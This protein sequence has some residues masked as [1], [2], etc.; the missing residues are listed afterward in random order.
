M[1]P[2]ES[3]DKDARVG[4]HD[5]AEVRL[6]LEGG[7]E[8]IASQRH[9]ARADPGD[10]AVGSDPLPHEPRPPDLGHGGHDEQ[11]DGPDHAHVPGDPL[12]LGNGGGTG[13]ES[14]D[15]G[16]SPLHPVHTPGA[17]RL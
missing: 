3:D 1:P 11:P 8:P 16:A 15:G 9:D 10:A 12:P 4:G 14:F 6:L 7:D 17:Q 2:P 13:G 5:P